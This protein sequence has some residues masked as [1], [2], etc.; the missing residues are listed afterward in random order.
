MEVG[1]V[2]VVEPPPP[3][4]AQTSTRTS[5]PANAQRKKPGFGVRGSEL[6]ANTHRADCRNLPT[7]PQPRTLTAASTHHIHGPGPR[8][9]RRFGETA[10]PAAVVT[11]AVAV[12][13]FGALS[14]SVDGVTTHE[15]AGAVVVQERVTDPLNP[16]VGAKFSV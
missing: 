4:P 9:E 10:P 7:K 11:V 2:D 16:P 15:A 12:A 5:A 3:Q 1:P 8:G 6:A 13:V 14:E